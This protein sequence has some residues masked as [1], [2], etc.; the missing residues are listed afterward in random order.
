[1]RTTVLAPLCLGFEL[2]AALI[3]VAGDHVC[4]LTHRVAVFREAQIVRI[5]EPTTNQAV[6]TSINLTVL[7]PPAIPNRL[8]GANV[9]VPA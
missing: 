1:M 6:G 9:T 5:A 8:G 3:V 4:G 7:E 2:F